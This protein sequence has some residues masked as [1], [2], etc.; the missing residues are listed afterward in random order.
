[1]K[2]Y[3]DGDSM[4]SGG[5]FLPGSD[6]RVKLYSQRI[7]PKWK[8]DRWSKI[9]CDRLGAEEYNYAHGGGSNQRILRQLTTIHNIDDYDLA[10][11]QMTYPERTEYHDGTKFQQMSPQKAMHS[12]KI[13]NQN[14]IWNAYYKNIYHDPFGDSMEKM[15]YECIKNIFRVKKIPLILV[16]SWHDTKLSFDHMI[17]SKVFGGKYDPVKW[18]GE[19]IDPHPNLESQPIIADDIYKFINIT[20]V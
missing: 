1:M 13:G 17:T 9:L 15:V 7:D 19:D 5:Y 20:S 18:I 2:I 11:I 4:T 12:K 16:S 10:I 3:F 8:T 6:G 14:W